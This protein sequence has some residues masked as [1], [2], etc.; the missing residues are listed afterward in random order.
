MPRGRAAS[1]P[2]SGGHQRPAAR[3]GLLVTHINEKGTDSAQYDF[4]RLPLSPQFQLELAT[5]FAARATPTGRWR[6][7]PTSKQAFWAV[8]YFARWLARQDR[9]PSSVADL[10]TA[11]WL[12]WRLEHMAGTGARRALRL[13]RMLLLE[14][15]LLHPQTRREVAKRVPRDQPTE[16]SYN[17]DELRLLA[18]A[19][20]RVWRMARDRIRRNQEHL[21]RYRAGE[22]E[23]GTRDYLVGQALEHIAVDGDVPRTDWKDRAPEPWVTRALGGGHRDQTW[24]R[25]Y[26]DDAEVMAA[27]VLLA[28]REGWNQTSIQE[29]KVPER[30]DGNS[31]QPVYRVELEKRRRRPPHRYETRNLTD[32]APDSTARLLRHIVEVTQPARDVLAAH[33]QPTDRL[34]VS[35]RAH[36]L[37]ASVE[38]MFQYGLGTH[39]RDNLR[40]MT[41]QTVNLR[42]VRKAVNN[43][44]LRAPNQNTRETHESVYLLRD[45]D[46]ITESEALIARGIERALTHAEM[47]EAAIRPDD[48]D[49]GEDTATATCVDPVK[50]PYSPWGVACTASFLLCLACHNAVV[51]PK[52]LGRLAYL[53]E[54]LTNRRNS[55]PP[56][57]WASE[58]EGHYGRLHSL[59]SE[60]YSEGQWQQALDT[61][62]DGDRTIVDYLL[63]GDLDT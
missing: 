49:I 22:F 11:T 16:A 14:T 17:D 3:V 51:M 32:S 50:S 53:Y 1:L 26:L 40:K 27:L 61:L 41:G 42:R 43:R 36:A 59:R 2:P 62:T 19:A 31:A 60:H 56:K 28:C 45:P 24:K 58:W 12:R 13:T 63:K 20:R 5:V 9:V 18:V 7:L 23:P 29:L 8:D 33:G 4:S 25:L 15:E 35:H 57:A 34:L 6:N 46:T 37:G 38:R 48:S 21:R 52:H 47:V 39:S 10:D 55:L 54:C 44:H 30:I